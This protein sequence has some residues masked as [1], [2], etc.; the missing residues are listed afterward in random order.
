MLFAAGARVRPLVGILK[1]P[2][3]GARPVADD[4]E[5]ERYYVPIVGPAGTVGGL[6]SLPT[7]KSPPPRMIVHRQ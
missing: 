4:V 6:W 3:V 5:M 2:S 1:R 7:C